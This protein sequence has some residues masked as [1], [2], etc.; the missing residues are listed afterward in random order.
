M[1]ECKYCGRNETACICH[2]DE[3]AEWI[4][5]DYIKELEQKNGLLSEELDCAKQTIEQ[6]REYMRE[7]ERDKELAN[8]EKKALASEMLLQAEK[9][10]DLEETNEHLEK[11]IAEHM[12]SNSRLAE[13]INIRLFR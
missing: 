11:E 9:V 5:D 6:A 1:T 13:M 3:K 7:L 10:R 12:R 2:P 4:R 8:I